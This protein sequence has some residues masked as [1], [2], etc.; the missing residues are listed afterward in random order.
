MPTPTVR[1]L[2][3]GNE[4]RHLRERAGL[5]LADAGEVIERT[6]ATVSKL[7]NGIT[8]IRQKPLRELVEHY[9]EVIGTGADGAPTDGGEPIDPDAFCELN[10]GAENRGRWRGYRSAHPAHFRMAVDLETDAESVSIYQTEVVYALFQTEEYMRSMFENVRY[11]D[12]E[13]E[14]RIKARIER[15]AI[16]RKQGSPEITAVLSES[17]LRRMYG[18]REVMARQMRHLADIAELPSVHLHVLPF[19]AIP[20]LASSFPFVHFRVPSVSTNA[21][22]LEFVYVEQFSNGD[23]L[24]GS[25]HVGAYNRLWQGLLG[26]ALDPVESRAFVLRAADEFD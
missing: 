2:Q 26:A 15:Q 14:N 24:D 22:P 3:L 9:A 20:S 11:G 8:G 7:E 18:S 5:E 21:P 10:K 25:T 16:L 12:V 1:R 13:T 23:Y 19:A 17:A 4:L 6:W